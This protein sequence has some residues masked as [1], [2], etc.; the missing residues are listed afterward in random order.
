MTKHIVSVIL[1]TLIVIFSASSTA[2][3]I[4]SQPENAIRPTEVITTVKPVVSIQPTIKPTKTPK[5][6]RKPKKKKVKYF[7][8]VK[9]GKITTASLKSICKY[10]GKKYDIDPNLLHAVVIIESDRN[11][12]CTGASGDK[13]LCQIVE[14]FHVERM[15]KLNVTDIYDSYSNI[16][17]CADFLSE[18]KKNKYGDDI[19]FVLMAYNMGTYGATKHYENGTISN[20]AYKVMD[21]YENLKG[22]D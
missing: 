4:E 6:T 19:Y 10:V 15:K 8:K 16:L 11:V 22:D 7:T 13:G 14:R 21:K 3:T 12:K 1:A 5:S 2:Q 17:L 20:Y 9:E 18:L